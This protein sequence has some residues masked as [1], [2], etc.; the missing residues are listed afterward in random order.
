MDPSTVVQAANPKVEDEKA[1]HLKRL[2][3][4]QFNSIPSGQWRLM[5]LLAILIS[6]LRKCET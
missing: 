3:M 6:V 5:P 2:K 1:R 4:K